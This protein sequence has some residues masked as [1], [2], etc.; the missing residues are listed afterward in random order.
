MILASIQVSIL[1]LAVIFLVLTILIGVINL[2][3]YLIP[4]KAPAAQPQRATPTGSSS[5]E[6]EHTA[7]IQVALAH[8]LGRTPQSISITNIQAR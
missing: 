5:N 1:A 6:E 8:H 4:Y 3:N 7:A 2:L